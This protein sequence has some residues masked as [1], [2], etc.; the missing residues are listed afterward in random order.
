M[1]RIGFVPLV[2]FMPCDPTY[3]NAYVPYQ[4]DIDELCLEEAM[5]E[6]TLFCALVSS[7]DGCLKGDDK[8][9]C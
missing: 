2:P 1:N 9:C 4:I 3:A 8:V 5:K 7:F 6:G